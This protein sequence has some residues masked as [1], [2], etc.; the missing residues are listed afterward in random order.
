MYEPGKGFGRDSKLAEDAGFPT[1]D[2][3][4]NVLDYLDGDYP[5]LYRCSQVNRI[6]RD[7]SAAYLYRSVTYS[8]AFSPVLN[9]RKQDDF[10]VCYVFIFHPYN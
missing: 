3:L 8:P 10:A 5:S 7:A 6:F 4:I 9:L 1:C 2:A